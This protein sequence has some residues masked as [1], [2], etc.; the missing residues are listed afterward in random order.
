MTNLLPLKHHEVHLGGDDSGIRG[1]WILH[2]PYC[3]ASPQ[4]YDCVHEARVGEH[5]R[6]KGRPLDYWLICSNRF[7]PSSLAILLPRI[8]DWLIVGW[9]KFSFLASSTVVIFSSRVPQ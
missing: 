8:T 7:N 6:N 5:R 1:D 9:A 3:K 2:V 4:T